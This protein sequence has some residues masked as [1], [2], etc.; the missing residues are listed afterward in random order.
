MK[1]LLI[2]IAQA[3][4][5]DPE[6]IR[7]TEIKAQPLERLGESTDLRLLNDVV[8]L[9]CERKDLTAVIYDICN[10]QESDSGC[11]FGKVSVINPPSFLSISSHQLIPQCSI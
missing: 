1:D 4:V 11:A 5:D 7:V 9:I 3:L 10:Y 6:Q 8:D 2:R